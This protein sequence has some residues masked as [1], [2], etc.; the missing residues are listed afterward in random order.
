[1]LS[2]PDHIALLAYALFNV[3]VPRDE[4]PKNWTYNTEGSHWV[5]AGGKV[6]EGDV[7]FQVTQYAHT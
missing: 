5:D 3:S 1:M 7:E 6:I 2:S 4:I